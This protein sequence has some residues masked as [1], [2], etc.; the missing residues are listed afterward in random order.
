VD[1]ILFLTLL[2]GKIMKSSKVILPLLLLAVLP[3]LLLA[4]Q[5]A[6][7]SVLFTLNTDIDYK[8][9]VMDTDSTLCLYNYAVFPPPQQILSVRRIGP[10]G[11]IEPQQTI[12]SFPGDAVDSDSF[13]RNF[14]SQI[15]D[16]SIYFVFANQDEIILL[17]VS[18]TDVTSYS[19]ANV[20]GM[21][22]ACKCGI[23]NNRVGFTVQ[24]S[25]D[26]EHL[27]F[28]DYLDDE[29]SLVYSFHPEARGTAISG[30]GPDKLL[31]SQSDYDTGSPEQYP[32]MIMDSQMNISPTNLYNTIV[33]PAYP[34]DE[35]HYF[36]YWAEFAPYG[37]WSATCQGIMTVD[38]G[39]ITFDTW[40]CISDMD[41][42]S[43]AWN[44]RLA[45]PGNLHTCIY[46][47]SGMSGDYSRYEIYSYDGQGNI[48]P[49]TGFPQVDNSLSAPKHV[50]LYQDKLLLISFADGQHEFR[51]ANLLSQEWIP[52]T[53]SPWEWPGSNSE[54]FNFINSDEYIYGIRRAQFPGPAIVSCMK[55]DISVST[56][57]PVAAPPALRAYP[58]PFKS[59]VKLEFDSID[60]CPAV[61]IYN[62]RG[63]KV[64]TLPSQPDGTIWDG[65]DASGNRLSSG[66]Y[67]ARPQSG[68][69]KVLKLLKLGD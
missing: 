15:V 2:G 20:A 5:T 66:I 52:V 11:V 62:L 51:L 16:N 34:F 49:Y 35:N 26:R 53:G 45:L 48:D 8:E 33:L 65:K 39:D 1:L 57:D 24:D 47:Y 61:E 12:Y 14:H 58:N 32:V 56:D 40:S 17:M 21:G 22:G 23:F 27:W 46:N 64:R 4:T 67:F 54:D 69:H 37:T 38:S 31:L 68:S 42:Y 59:S 10:N 63:Q 60:I 9:A 18:G 25:E 13:Y 36:A 44:F 41:P 28:W 6:D 43:E 50:C 3:V 29:I 30:L 7:L 55:L 19:I